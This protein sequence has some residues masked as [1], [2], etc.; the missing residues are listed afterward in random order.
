MIR[1]QFL[2]RARRAL[3]MTSSVVSVVF[4]RRGHAAA[5]VPKKEA[6]KISLMTSFRVYGAD[7]PFF[8]AREK[9]YFAEQGVDLENV[10]G[11]GSSNTAKL[12]ASG[13][14]HVGLVDGGVVI[15]SVAE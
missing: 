3:L 5:Q 7:A 8:L 11:T 2:E 10:E 1:R 14:A 6:E 9:G 13:A 12:V 15:R 4:S